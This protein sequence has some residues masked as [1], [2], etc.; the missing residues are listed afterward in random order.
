VIKHVYTG[1]EKMKQHITIGDWLKATEGL[2]K[3]WRKMLRGFEG[4]C[5]RKVWTGLT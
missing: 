4:S 2:E 1:G 3:I 5:N